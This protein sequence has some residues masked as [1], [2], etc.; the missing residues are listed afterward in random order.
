[1]IGIIGLYLV[2]NNSVIVQWGMVA[3][4]TVLPI[5]YTRFYSLA[6]AQADQKSSAKVERTIWFSN[7]KSLTQFPASVPSAT[8]YLAV[9][10]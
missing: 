10:F 2:F 8:S 1:M 5:A 3:S 9:G 4:T 6:F 7:N